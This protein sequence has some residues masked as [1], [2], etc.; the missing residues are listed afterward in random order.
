[1][2]CIIV[3]GCSDR[4]NP[5]IAKAKELR[6]ELKESGWQRF[7]QDINRATNSKLINLKWLDSQQAGQESFRKYSGFCCYGN[8]LKPQPKHLHNWDRLIESGIPLALWQLHHPQDQ[9]FQA[10]ADHDYFKFLEHI[11]IVREEQ[12]LKG[13]DYLGVFYEDPDHVPSILTEAVQ[14]Y[15]SF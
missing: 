5:T 4:Y 9:T 1:H 15:Q 10:F 6:Q 8:W 14:Y 12:N 3:F 2:R 13:F 11:P 7:Q